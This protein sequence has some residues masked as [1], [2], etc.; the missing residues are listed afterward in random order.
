[1]EQQS[2][3][4]LIEQ[5]RNA[6]IQYRLGT[7]IIGDSEYDALIEEFRTLSTEDEFDEFISELN[8]GVIE[9]SENKVE[10]PFVLGSLNKLKYS[11]PETINKFISKRVGNVMSVSA[12]IDG[13][14]CRLHYENGKLTQAST[15]GDGYY[16]QDITDKIKFIK[17]IPQF[18]GTKTIDIRGELVILKEDFEKMEGFANPR[19]ACAGIINRKDSSQSE[20]KNISF[21]A[22]TIL[23]DEFEKRYQFEELS[24]NGFVVA[25]HDELSISAIIENDEDICEI[26]FNIL[27]N[28]YPYEVDGL[29]ISSV[30]YKNENK[31]KPDGCVAFKTNQLGAI[32]KVIDVSFEGPSK[33]GSV[34][35]VAILEPVI[36][37]G[38]CINRATL[39]NNDYIRNKGIKYGSVVEVIKAGDI[40]PKVIRV[41]DNSGAIDIELPET[42]PCCGTQLVETELYMKCP[43][44][45]CKD[46]TTY[47]TQHFLE[48]LNIDNVSFKRLQQ[49]NI[50]TIRDLISFVPNEKYKIETKLYS[51][52]KTKMFCRSKRD[53]FVATNF[54]GISKKILNKIFDFYGFEIALKHEN[55]IGL[56]VGVG[57]KTMEKFL[58]YVDENV[59]IVNDIISDNRYSYVEKHND[60]RLSAS[61]FIG[62]ICFTGS[63]SSMGRKEASSLAERNGFEV[64]NSVT[65][66]LTYLVTSDPNSNST[67]SK[68]AREFGTIVIGE[69][70]FLNMMNS[71]GMNV[72]DL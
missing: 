39:H 63:L 1:M 28:N 52:L 23:G 2:K 3:T 31:Y 50:F 12:K 26:L 24:S 44:K 32:T 57:E 65:R 40:I 49:L 21:I 4:N 43:N 19:N 14:S 60:E 36:L 8:E 41:V 33:D 47:Q 70:E 11:E 59:K 64:K 5:I 34:V 67:K 38:S 35:P 48:K 61:T 69:T 58:Q 16:G 7:P 6:N 30:H 71:N 42:C 51:D 55:L 56:P 10:H 68:K 29:V 22:Y 37:G 66:G 15:R 20:L 27:N 62:S 25:W 53:L 17:N 46:Q 18:F 13:I 72:D 45:D 9:N 54:E